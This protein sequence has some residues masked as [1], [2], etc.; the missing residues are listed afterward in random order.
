[1]WS[2]LC[3]KAKPEHE[4]EIDRIFALD[5]NPS[6]AAIGIVIGGGTGWPLLESMLRVQSARYLIPG[7][8][9]AE[10]PQQSA[11]KEE[12]WAGEAGEL[13]KQSLGLSLRTRSKKLGPIADE[14]WEYL[15]VSELGFDLPER[16]LPNRCAPSPTHRMSSSRW[17]TPCVQVCAISRASMRS[18]WN[19]HSGSRRST[20][21]KTP[22]RAC[23]CWAR[24]T[25]AFE[26]LRRIDG[27]RAALLSGELDVWTVRE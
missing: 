9:R 5:P 12:T 14:L 24:D 8:P 3:K 23:P 4:H 21:S 27:A 6:F 16:G 7:A 26:A 19:R 17:S 22:V 18:M 15:L 2:S 11:L 10:K 1:M 20:S 25:F 13:L